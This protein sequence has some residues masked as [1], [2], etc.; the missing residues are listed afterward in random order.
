MNRMRLLISFA[1][2]ATLLAAL[3]APPRAGEEVVAAAERSSARVSSSI[4]T[5]SAPAAIEILAIRPRKVEDQSVAAFRISIPAVKERPVR[6]V[7]V[8]EPKLEVE[9]EQARQPPAPP[10]RVL[11]R[12]V[13]AGE[14]SVFLQHNE[15]NIVARVGDRLSEHYQLESL[16]QGVVTLLYLPLGVRQTLAAGGAP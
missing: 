1:L 8:A 5:G 12:Y 9:V 10:F 13:E 3:L 6:V 2:A 7:A 15:Q 11:G 4:A 14:E 16:E